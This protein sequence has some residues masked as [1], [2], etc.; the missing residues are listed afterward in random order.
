MIVARTSHWLCIVGAFLVVVLA[1]RPAQAC[2][3]CFGDPNSEMVKGAKAGV[4]VL[5]VIVYAVLLTFASVA[6]F[7]MFKAKRLA[8][9]QDMPGTDV[10]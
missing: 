5:V 8:A 6:G 2:A 1:T 3:V 7:W 4:L 10:T 9:Q